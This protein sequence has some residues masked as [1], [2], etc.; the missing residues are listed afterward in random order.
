MTSQEIRAKFLDFFAA[1]GHTIVP[2]S[3]L[4]PDDPSVLFT[5][6]GMQQFKR[7]YT[8]ELDAVKD[9]KSKNAASA[10]KC[11]RTS[12]IDE[13]GDESHLTFFEM[14]GNFSFGGYFK[15]ETIVYAHEFI[16]K[17]LGLPIDYV[18]VFAGDK[19]V[20]ADVESEKIWKLLGVTNIKK[21][22]REDNFWGPTGAEGPCG[23]TSEVYV[24]GV[25]VWNLVFNEFYCGKDK[26]L[27]PLKTKGIDTGMG[28]E[29]LT[30]M[31]QGKPT[32]FETDTFEPLLK[33]LPETMPV[34]I[35]RII[36]DHVRG[37][38]F[39][40]SDGVRPSNKEAGYV[41]RRLMRRVMVHLHLA[42][43]PV[44]PAH[45]FEEVFENCERFY[46]ELN[47]EMVLEVFDEEYG[48][49]RATLQKGLRE[50]AQVPALD[51]R[52]AFMLY[53]S[54]G[55]PYEIIK[56]LGGDKANN[57][58]REDFDEEFKKHQE[59]SRAGVEKKFGGHGLVLDTG[60]LKAG[61]EEE[62]KKVT[63]YHTATHLLHQALREVLGG[64]IAQR[65]S[66]ITTERTRFD[67][68]F[69]RKVTPEE[70]K[71]VEEIV[72]EKIREDLPVQFQEMPKEEAEKT[73]AL[74]FFKGKYPAR[75]KVYYVGHSLETAWNKE[76]CGGP[77]VAH[78][79]EIGKFRILKE[80]ASSAGVRRIR[81][82][83]E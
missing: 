34:R 9:F 70:L 21:C 28:L 22:G 54:F 59:T 19:E 47:R 16:T 29:R 2:S 26:K 81:A 4:V 50:L 39:L 79:G 71:R 76:F 18:S 25:E 49:F 72:N 80:E 78:T 73:G 40:V 15:K 10:Q 58:K 45:L 82:T 6:A 56:E 62:L 20:P 24:R 67:F 3:S 52:S 65:G 30:M 43:N 14:L 42:D 27:T 51:V 48:R 41:L 68:T 17:E 44:A 77:H 53:A 57:L 63:R 74:Y 38:A 37:I 36:A 7:Y 1:R 46:Q 61:S 83:V 32:I 35:K 69:S 23:P 5:T 8:G 75:V 33:L 60:E 64:E 12:D 13:V 66:D 31:V 55:L 11:F